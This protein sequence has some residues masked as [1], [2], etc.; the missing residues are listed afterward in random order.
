VWRELLGEAGTSE[1]EEARR[2]ERTPVLALKLAT[3]VHAISPDFEEAAIGA[4][5]AEFACA[6]A[7]AVSV[8]DI[9]FSNQMQRKSADG[10]TCPGQK[11]ITALV[12]KLKLR[13]PLRWHDLLR[14][15]R[16]QKAEPLLHLLDK[17]VTAGLICKVG[18]LFQVTEV[19]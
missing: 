8:C 13:G 11:E 5:T 6:L 9:Q 15:Q 4:Q 7:S 10:R 3:L 17:A 18:D 14:S 2:L 19:A 16:V 12:A 1:P